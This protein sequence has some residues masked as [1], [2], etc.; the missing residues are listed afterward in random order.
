MAS[1]TASSFL[2]VLVILLVMP[3]PETTSAEAFARYVDG[4]VLRVGRGKAWGKGKPAVRAR[5]RPDHRHSSRPELCRIGERVAERKFVTAGL[6]SST[7]NGMDGFGSA[8]TKFKP[9]DLVGVGCL[10]DADMSCPHCRAG[11]EQFSP[12][13]DVN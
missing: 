13:G 10:V 11:N 9:G 5:H 8:V 2:A 7:N 6:Q 3:V 12:K 4:K 1:Q